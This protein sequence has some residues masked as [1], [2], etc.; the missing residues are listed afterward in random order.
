MLT[1]VR[2]NPTIDLHFVRLAGGSFAL[3]NAMMLM[4]KEPI[5][6]TGMGRIEMKPKTKP[7]V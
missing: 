2:P 6:S 5:I 1:T 7:A 4:I 3:T